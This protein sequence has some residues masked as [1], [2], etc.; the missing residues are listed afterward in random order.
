MYWLLE[1]LNIQWQQIIHG[2]Q[3][4]V[5]LGL[6]TKCVDTS[7]HIDSLDFEWVP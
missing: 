6:G 5:W 2:T 7:I 1:L 4:F 3:G